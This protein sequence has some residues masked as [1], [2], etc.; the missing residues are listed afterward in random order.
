M[1]GPGVNSEG[2]LATLPLKACF[3]FNFGRFMETS[4]FWT[5]KE[6]VLE[7]SV[8]SC[9]LMTND[10]HRQFDCAVDVHLKDTRDVKEARGHSR[11]SFHNI[12]WRRKFCYNDWYIRVVILINGSF[13]RSCLVN[14]ESFNRTEARSAHRYLF[15]PDERRLFL[16]VPLVDDELYIFLL[17]GDLAESGILF[18]RD[19]TAALRSG[20]NRDIM[21]ETC[22]LQK[23][24]VTFLNG[25]VLNLLNVDLLEKPLPLAI[26]FLQLISDSTSP[27]EYLQN[28][29]KFPMAYSEIDIQTIS[30]PVSLRLTYIPTCIVII[31]HTLIRPALSYF[32]QLSIPCLEQDNF[33]SQTN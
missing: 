29:Q 32:F 13:V 24:E 16:L 18:T 11:Q 3:S 31:D 19:S 7:E 25:H 2:G 30:T 5:C 22:A 23:G 9:G 17:F 28:L 20:E 12:G 10:N 4:T 15:P 14:S 27:N 8:A 33:N 26:N 1:I 6:T 21:E